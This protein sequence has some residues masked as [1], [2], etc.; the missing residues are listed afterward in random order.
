MICLPRC[1]YILC[2]SDICTSAEPRLNQSPS[3]PPTLQVT[4]SVCSTGSRSNTSV[5][6][7]TWAVVA[8]RP[9]SRWSSSTARWAAHAS[10]SVRNAPERLSPTPPRIS[11]FR[12]CLSTNRDYIIIIFFLL[13]FLFFQDFFQD[14]L[15]KNLHFFFFF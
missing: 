6:S 9:S 2:H 4:S 15:D 12:Q 5:C 13:S 1:L 7:T 11:V 3:L 14:F 10:A 8:R